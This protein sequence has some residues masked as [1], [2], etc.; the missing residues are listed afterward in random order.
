MKYYKLKECT[1][2]Q[3]EELMEVGFV[4][5]GAEEKLCKMV[6]LLI[7]NFLPAIF[8]ICVMVACSDDD[9]QPDPIVDSK[10]WPLD[11]NMDKSYRPGDNFF[12]YCNGTW[13]KNADVGDGDYVG[14]DAEFDK[15]NKERINSLDNET[16]KKFW[17]DA[18]D[19]D[20][21]TDAAI[22]SIKKDLKVVENLHTKEEAWAAIGKTMQM[23][24]RKIFDFSPFPHK[25][26]MY[27][28]IIPAIIT[29]I[30]NATWIVECLKTVGLA[31]SEAELKARKV[32]ELQQ[33]LVNTAAISNRSFLTMEAYFAQQTRVIPLNR[34]QT[35][36]E[37][38]Y[39][40]LENI[41]E[42]IGISPE[43]TL[44]TPESLR[45]ISILQAADVATIQAMLQFDIASF[46]ALTS[47]EKLKRLN[48]LYHMDSTIE[49]YL[50]DT[51][52]TYMGY[53]FSYAYA[54]KYVPEAR[55]TK[56]KEISEEL[57]TVF[58]ERISALSWLSESTK[59]RALKKLAAMK[60][61]V[62]YPDRW[63]VEGL[64]KLTGSSFLED[65]R[66]L[67]MAKFAVNKS[68]IG[69]NSQDVSFDYFIN[70]WYD[71]TNFNA[72]YMPAMNSI[73]IYPAFMLAP[74]YKEDVSDAYNYAM[75]YVI[76]HEMTHGFDSK[77]ANYNEVGD[78]EDWWT[79]TDRQKFLAKQQLLID[80]YN[81]FEVMPDELPGLHADGKKTLNENIADLGG[82]EI[83][84]QA[85]VNKL[86][87]EGY[88][89]EE[90][91][92]QEKKFYQ[93]YAEYH[94][95][96]FSVKGIMY[97]MEHDNHSLEKERVNGVVSNC[98]RWYE[99]YNVKP[100]DK[101][102]LKPEL[103]CYIW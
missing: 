29:G 8:A 78:R 101:L 54:T 82:V 80:C 49:G 9:I 45:Y 73:S 72:F 81:R 39:E 25:G 62:G 5:N 42:A 16:I 4:G 74:Y 50:Q 38:G 20:R 40:M 43:N 52:Y 30:D 95:K 24:Y 13:Y 47:R 76:G 68:L 3:P 98:D 67:R 36:G 86:K 100:D 92:K 79:E 11:G 51:R 85:Y 84:H 94:R 102:Y 57:R 15:T 10:E 33:R 35:R 91:I 55:K 34:A 2:Y 23:G 19:V 96:K 12:M 14:L 7:K 44:I 93:A 37:N 99:L 59:Q 31:D 22:A 103:R 83:A 97:Y 69:K 66:Q 6:V 56:F 77:G 63:L 53:L 1:R 90:L 64:P 58:R 18:A 32:I 48:E 65:L 21:T 17:A 89:G 41:V 75:A 27:A 46:V 60:F 61:N 71:L 70:N 88:T 26:N 87:R 28:E